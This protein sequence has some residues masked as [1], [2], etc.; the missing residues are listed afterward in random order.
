MW[1]K[2]RSEVIYQV[3]KAW[4]REAIIKGPTAESSGLRNV[5]NKLANKTEK[6]E[7]EEVNQTESKALG[8]EKKVKVKVNSSIRRVIPVVCRS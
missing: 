4:N 7:I 8:G 1:R 5:D 3:D 6:S 2:R